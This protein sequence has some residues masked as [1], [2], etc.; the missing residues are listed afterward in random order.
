M[1]DVRRRL[2]DFLMGL[3]VARFVDAIDYLDDLRNAAQERGKRG[4]GLDVKWA[5]CQIAIGKERVRCDVLNELVGFNEKKKNSIRRP[6]RERN[7]S[8]PAVGRS[9]ATSLRETG[10]GR[11]GDDTTDHRESRLVRRALQVW[12]LRLEAAPQRPR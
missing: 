4:A 9:V 3:G 2:V 8:L 7:R 6:L 5:R 1:D 12:A 10:T 11:R